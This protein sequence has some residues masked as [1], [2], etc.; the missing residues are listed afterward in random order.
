M[1]AM[2]SGR[3]KLSDLGLAMRL[4]PKIQALFAKLV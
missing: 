3:L 1:R 2:M 4:Q